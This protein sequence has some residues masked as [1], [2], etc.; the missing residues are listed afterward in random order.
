LEDLGLG[1]KRKKDWT[2]LA[3]DRNVW[4]AVVNTAMNLQENLLTS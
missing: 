1:G 2:N 4:Q 3:H